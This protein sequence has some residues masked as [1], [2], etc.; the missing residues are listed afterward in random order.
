M[1]EAAVYILRNGKEELVLDSVDLLEPDNGTIRMVNI[2]GEQK[3]VA[4]KFKQLSLVNHKIILE[5][6]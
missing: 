3:V 2:F 6:K 1:C 5:D 4:A